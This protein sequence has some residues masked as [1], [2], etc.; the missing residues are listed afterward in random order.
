MRDLLRMASG[1]DYQAFRPLIFNSDDPLTTYFPDQR[2]ISLENTQIIEP[3]G[4]HFRYQKYHPQLLGMILERTTGMSVTLYLQTRL[5]NPLGMEYPG[6]WSTDS[7]RSDF[8]KME[9]GVNARAIDFAKLGALFLNE[10]MWQGQ[11]V[12]SK[13][14]VTEATQPFMAED[15][16]AYYPPMFTTMPGGKGYYGYMWWGLAREGGAYDF[17]AEGDKGQFIYVSPSRKLVIVRNGIDF[18][19][20]TEEWITLFYNY[21]NEWPISE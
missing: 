16:P 10:G 18:G 5:W 9:T 2:K 4:E 19:N 3:A 20:P 14:W 7:E 8:E 15:K 1:L 17:S 11:Q 6:S 12:I 13:T 21:A